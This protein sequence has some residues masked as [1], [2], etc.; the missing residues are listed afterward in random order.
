[1]TG[2]SLTS[3]DLRSMVISGMVSDWSDGKISDSFFE[4]DPLTWF[5]TNKKPGIFADHLFLSYLSTMLNHDI[6]IVHMTP[7]AVANKMF[8]W[9]KG[10]SLVFFSSFSRCC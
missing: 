6:I 9:I 8:C 3:I 10:Q 5:K 7:S 2:K 1:M 4:P